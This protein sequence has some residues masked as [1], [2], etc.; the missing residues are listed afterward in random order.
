MKKTSYSLS[1]FFFN[2]NNSTFFFPIAP[3]ILFESIPFFL[4]LFLISLTI[5]S[6]RP[7]ANSKDVL[8]NLAFSAGW[9]EGAPPPRLPRL[10]KS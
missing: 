4:A 9:S 1:L 6:L 7:F 5:L 2:C 10:L 8:P 3:L